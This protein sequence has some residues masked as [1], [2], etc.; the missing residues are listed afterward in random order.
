[1]DRIWLN[2]M[3]DKAMQNARGRVKEEKYESFRRYVIYEEPVDKVSADL[4]IREG[5]IFQHKSSFLDI[6]REELVK[7]LADLNDLG[8]M[9]KDSPQARKQFKRILEDYIQQQKEMRNTMIS[10]AAPAP[11]V[12]RV[13]QFQQ[14]YAKL[15]LD[16]ST[17]TIIYFKDI[18]EINHLAVSSSITIGRTAD[19]EIHIDETKI[20]ADHARIILSE[21][22][23][24]IKDN[25]ST[26]GIWK[27][28]RRVGENPLFHGDW[29]QIGDWNFL[30]VNGLNP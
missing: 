15:K 14:I 5:T 9:M 12:D 22:G 13:I 25:N 20:S 26:N 18:N 7:L 4:G 30:V 19:A 21:E 2:R 10:N 16:P 11:V 28:G 6:L 29:I 8:P 23:L 24:H 1:M 17:P 3:I 27:N